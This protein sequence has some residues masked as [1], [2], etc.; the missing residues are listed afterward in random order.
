MSIT[1]EF[2]LSADEFALGSALLADP[3]VHV[4]FEQVVPTSGEVLPFVWAEGG[5]LEQF[6]R[7][8]SES[9]H[10]EGLVPL[11]RH[12]DRALYR[13]DWG[14]A[15][16]G[17]LH[18]LVETGATVLRAWGGER[19][20]FRLRFQD[21]TDLASFQQYVA[22]REFEFGLTRVR[23]ETDRSG[24]LSEPQYEAIALAFER[25][26]FSVPRGTTLTELSDELGVSEQAVSE[27][28]RRGTRT[29]LGLFL[30]DAH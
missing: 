16:E 1:V 28:L 20:Q 5:D 19:W 12:G 26:Y 6:E 29:L 27:R 14:S 4:E 21:H 2:S 23:S 15:V 17:F 24:P 10:V 3:P 18:A 25:G 30:S 9:R 8:V 7:H 13:I 11:D 22:E